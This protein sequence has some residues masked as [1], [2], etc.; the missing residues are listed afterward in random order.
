MCTECITPINKV[1]A[2]N[3]QAE[4]FNART[5]LHQLNAAVEFILGKKIGFKI[6]NVLF[7]MDT[8]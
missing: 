7:L 2:T 4:K 1:T 6:D 3:N 8:R 5:L